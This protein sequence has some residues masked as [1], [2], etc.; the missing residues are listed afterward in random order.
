MKLTESLE[1]ELEGMTPEYQ[2]KL[3]HM[4][5]TMS[6]MGAWGGNYG[7]MAVITNRGDIVLREKDAAP[8]ATTDKKEQ[9]E[10]SRKLVIHLIS[11]NTVA[12]IENKCVSIVQ[13]LFSDK[14]VVVI[15]EADIDRIK[16]H[17]KKS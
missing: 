9:S 17:L 4:L 14:H 13:Q 8:L 5:N 6:A 7:E 12:V 3:A 2:D 16:K 10:M 1:Q 11:N 15:N